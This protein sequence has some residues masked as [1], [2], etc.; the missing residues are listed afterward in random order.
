MDPRHNYL[1]I[2]GWV[3]KKIKYYPVA[4]IFG[5]MCILPFLFTKF[6]KTFAMNTDTPHTILKTLQCSLFKWNCILM[7]CNLV[8][9]QIH[10]S[11]RFVLYVNKNE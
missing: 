7:T 2:L 5:K 3:E 11:E 6:I 1:M 9:S 4:K 8:L 10:Y